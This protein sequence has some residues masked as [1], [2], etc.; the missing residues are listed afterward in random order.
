MDRFIK[1]DKC[2]W[3]IIDELI[4]FAANNNLMRLKRSGSLLLKKKVQ[5]LIETDLD[6]LTVE[7]WFISGDVFAKKGGLRRKAACE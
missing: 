4:F 1:E 5:F 3:S 7:E 2:T 6:F